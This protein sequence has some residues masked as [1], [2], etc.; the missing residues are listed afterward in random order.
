MNA[1]TIEHPSR[2]ALFSWQIC[3]LR[4]CEAKELVSFLLG[5][6]RFIVHVQ[7]HVKLLLQF[8]QQVRALICPMVHSFMVVAVRFSS[9]VCLRGVS[10]RCPCYCTCIA[11]TFASPALAPELVGALPLSVPL[12][13][14]PHPQPFWPP[15]CM[16][17][18]PVLLGLVLKGKLGFVT[19]LLPRMCIAFSIVL[20]YWSLPSR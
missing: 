17:A 7:I 13:C 2:Y 14:P 5:F 1:I 19:G 10:S 8:A 15:C 12:L 3:L 6:F 9:A 18:T 20:G 4:E 11:C 16:N